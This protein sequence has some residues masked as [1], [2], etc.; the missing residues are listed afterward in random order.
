MGYYLLIKEAKDLNL[1]YLCKCIDTKDHI[2]YK[3]S[4]TYWL[5]QIKEYD[6]KIETTVLG[7]YETNDS[8]KKAGEYYSALFDV[9]N[10][11]QWAN[12]MPEVGDGGP[13]VSG[14]V[15]AYNPENNHQQET[16][17]SENAIP[18][19]WVRGCRKWKKNPVGVEKTRLAHIGKTR[20]N[21]TRSNMSNAQRTI[22]KTLC[23]C[24]REFSLSNLPKHRKVCNG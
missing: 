20:S 16:F 10:D 7:Y 13:T 4:G 23:A 22:K 24:G 9:V 19:G 17:L 12:T 5:K 14:R 3:G 2:A 15:R 18:K 11:P 21:E 8:L 1:K 6:P